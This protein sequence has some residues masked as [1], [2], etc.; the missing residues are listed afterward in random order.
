VVVWI[1]IL[2][3]L[4]AAA[5]PPLAPA[6]QGPAE[7]KV[8]SPQPP[9]APVASPAP[10]KPAPFEA[11]KS[12]PAALGA[13]ALCAE[14]GRAAKARAEEIARLENEKAALAADRAELQKLAGQIQT[15][16]TQLR[17][18]TDRLA[19]F[20]ELASEESKPGSSGYWRNRLAKAG[21]TASADS[22]EALAKTV[23]AMKPAAAAE[24]VSKLDRNLGA[25]VLERLRPQDA[26][27][28]LD[29]I[30][31]DLAAELF[32]LLAQRA[33]LSKEAKK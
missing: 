31:P 30:K 11:E 1:A 18:E 33:A 12:V 7:P 16:R 4:V 26:S 20:V 6:P 17:E 9:A 5:A 25:A 15:A 19:S 24:L 29:R 28:V 3:P 23:K 2:V 32:N 27:A 8:A 10:E 13:P 22:F 14:L 21:P